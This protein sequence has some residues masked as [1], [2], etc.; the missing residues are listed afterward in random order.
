MVLRLLFSIAPSMIVW[1]EGQTHNDAS[2]WPDERAI[3]TKLEGAWRCEHFASYSDEL[4]GC[5]IE[6]FTL[7]RSAKRV[8]L[9]WKS[10]WPEYLRD[11]SP[12]STVIYIASIPHRCVFEYAVSEI[13]SFGK[14]RFTMRRMIHGQDG[15]LVSLM[16]NGVIGSIWHWEEK[17][18]FV[19]LQLPEGCRSFPY[20]LKQGKIRNRWTRIVNSGQQTWGSVRPIKG[21][22]YEVL[23][24]MAGAWMD[25]GVDDTTKRT[26][27]TN[28]VVF[29]S[30]ASGQRLVMESDFEPDLTHVLVSNPEKRCFQWY[31]IAETTNPEKPSFT[32]LLGALDEKGDSILW[33][34]K[35]E[36]AELWHFPDTN[37]V[38]R[39]T[40]AKDDPFDVKKGV[41]L[42]RWVR[43]KKAESGG[44]P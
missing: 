37:T 27:R 43:E 34:N 38:W 6:V 20:D 1:G 8:M 19:G 3:L 4:T 12:E 13:R 24:K 42:S 16:S 21:K 17:D 5:A 23:I 33:K 41:L 35:G 9:E 29:T 7:S 10:Q 11:S 15:D 39:L 30:S 2:P 28:T 44:K 26:V 40:P 14:P 25:R 22:E 32:A 18:R 31:Q 36:P